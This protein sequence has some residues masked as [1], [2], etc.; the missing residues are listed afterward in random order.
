MILR[1]RPTFS[2][3]NESTMCFGYVPPPPVLSTKPLTTPMPFHFAT[4]DRV[5][6]A[7]KTRPARGKENA[8]HGDDALE[9]PAVLEARRPKRR[10]VTVPVSPKFH[11]TTRQRGERRHTDTDGTEGDAV[12][13]RIRSTAGVS[14]VPHVTSKKALTVCQAIHLHTEARARLH[15]CSAHLQHVMAARPQ[16]KKRKIAGTRTAHSKAIRRSKR[17]QTPRFKKSRPPPAIVEEE[18][19]TSE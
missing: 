10:A 19:G 11:T 18:G 3:L 5:G 13:R 16:Q 12:S 2:D 14:G 15:D 8:G 17:Q 1:P 9:K 7:R 6:Q 4:D